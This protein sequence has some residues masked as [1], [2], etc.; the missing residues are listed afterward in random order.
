[1]IG[2]YGHHKRS[3]RTTRL[4]LSA[5][6]TKSKFIKCASKIKSELKKTAGN[7]IKYEDEKRMLQL[8]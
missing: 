3:G 5:G 1:M 8:L 4:G 6:V 7:A 2:V